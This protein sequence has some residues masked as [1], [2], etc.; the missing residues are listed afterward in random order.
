MSTTTV[1]SKSMFS[2]EGRTVD[3]T[4]SSMLWKLVEALITTK[5]WIK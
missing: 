4:R 5:H 1:A 3:E 2:M